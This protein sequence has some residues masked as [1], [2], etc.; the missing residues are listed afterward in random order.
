MPSSIALRAGWKHRAGMSQA[1]RQL[2]NLP[3][4]G[5]VSH[6][7]SEDSGDAPETARPRERHDVSKNDDL[8]MMTGVLRIFAETHAGWNES[9]GIFESTN[10]G[11]LPTRGRRTGSHDGTLKSGRE[12]S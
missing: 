3:D 8:D 4:G 7:I 9:R 6:P 12:A 5:G 11:E 10:A 1:C 2:A